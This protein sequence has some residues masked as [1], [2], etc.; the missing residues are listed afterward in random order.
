VPKLL[1]EDQINESMFFFCP[2]LA[3]I[4]RHMDEHYD[5]P[6]SLAQAAEIASLEKTYF[7]KVFRA[8]VGVSFAEWLAR[9]RIKRALLMLMDHD[10]RI[11][12]L[13]FAVGFGDLR[14]FERAF[15][16]FTGVTPR[17]CKS[18]ARRHS[19]SG[20]VGSRPRWE[21]IAPT[22]HDTAL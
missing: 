12:D 5:E 21:E 8:K 19:E 9:E 11:A 15:K 18:I 4:K 2:R 16:K 14:T 1:L 20:S 6:F 3:K 17:E 7:G 22:L 13:A 10:H